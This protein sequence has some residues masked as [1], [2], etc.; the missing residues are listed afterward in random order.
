VE[1]E[2]MIRRYLATGLQS[3][4]HHARLVANGEDGLAAFAKD[5]FD[6]V[7]TDLGLP[8]MSGEDVARG[9]A[10]TARGTPVI[11]FT[12]WADQLQAESGAPDG[13]ARV[14]SKPITLDLL[15]STL[16]AVCPG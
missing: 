5:Q 3:M 16:A 12:G 14:L 2:E 8:G 10:A 6:L 11:L 13:I 9:I 7:L 1:D 4:G 15:A